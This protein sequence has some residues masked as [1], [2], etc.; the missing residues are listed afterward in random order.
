MFKPM[1][2]AA[3][4]HAK[5]LSIADQ[6]EFVLSAAEML[7]NRLDWTNDMVGKPA[8]ALLRK[9][10]PFTP[11]QVLQ[12]VQCGA[13]PSYYF[14]F[15]GVLRLAEST[16]MTPELDTALR[17]MQKAYVLQYGQAEGHRAII[18]RIGDLLNGNKDDAASFEPA[19][20]W[21][22]HIAGEITLA[23]RRVLEA[24][25]DISGSEPS[26]KWHDAAAARISEIGVEAFRTTAIRWLEIGPNPG[27]PT[28]QIDAKEADYQRGLLWSLTTF[29][30]SEMCS[31]VARFAEACFHKVPMI[32][33]VSHKSGNA[34][35]NVLAAMDGKEPVAQLSRLAMRIKYQTAQRLVQQALEA[36][37]VR[38]GIS[39]D[40]LQEI[41]V[42]TCGLDHDGRRVEQLCEYSL[43]LNSA[44]ELVCK[45]AEG[46]ILK[47]LPDVLKREFA[48]AIKELKDVAKEIAA[49]RSAHR[50]R[51]ERLLLSGRAIPLET[52]RSAY[53]DHPL[54][55]ELARRLI[56]QFE[57]GATAIWYEG[58]L[59]NWGGDNV[60]PEASV[61][62]WHPIHS[63]VQTVL[64][65][66][67]WL[68]DRRVQQPF[69]QAHREV[70]IL[71]DAERTTQFHSNRF[72][73]HILKQH[74]FQALC[75]QRGWRFKL[76]GAWDSHN[77]PAL[78]LPQ[79]KLRV[80]YDVDFPKDEAVSGHMIYLYLAT[81]KIRF[82]DAETGLPRPIDSIPPAVF[83][84]VM[85]DIDLFVGVSSIGNDPTW[86]QRGPA[87]FAGYWHNFSFGDL[88]ASAEQRKDIVA[89]LVSKLPIKDRCRVED[90]FLYVRGDRA[91]YKIHLGSGSVMI[92]PGSRYL[93][94]VRGA[95]S[96]SPAKVFLPFEN[97]PMLSTILSK[98]FLLAADKKMTDPSI[99]RQ[100][101]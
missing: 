47:S 12:L 73:G 48:P 30:D 98:A 68:E 29:S 58:R 34:C 18:A 52:W 25:R 23:W 71:T 61:R 50:V 53:I 40:E 43:E 49:L 45:S 8:G 4:D 55:G 88:S 56:W 60:E 28:P 39:R 77:T 37:A 92:E 1:F 84:E 41:S 16:P 20:S 85:R 17:A 74:Q 5:G 6:V 67:C 9:K 101:P 76:M 33:A 22:R 13:D 46:K 57:S 54:I 63:D 62:L 81:D 89:Q 27:S 14:P 96:V 38:Q 2:Q 31:A 26:N 65:W 87:P 66:R 19:G 91:T 97:D 15:A 95:S 70:Y 44:G 79:F 80:E 75:E 72:A 90:R 42:P 59:I 86:G 83:S 32:G 36:A 64:S 3:I 7:R 69:K 100:L 21:T 93:C 78:D 82:I 10:L 24:G 11:E 51:I 99:T 35:V 94:I